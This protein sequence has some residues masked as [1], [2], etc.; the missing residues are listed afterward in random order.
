MMI[1]LPRKK[2]PN[3]MGV[4]SLFCTNGLFDRALPL[5]N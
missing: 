5:S 1:R 3:R 4:V 2:K